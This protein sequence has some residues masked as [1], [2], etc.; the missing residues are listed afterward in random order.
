MLSARL[1][2]SNSYPLRP[3]R[4][5][6]IQTKREGV[7]VKAQ[8]FIRLLKLVWGEYDIV[9]MNEWKKK[10]VDLQRTWVSKRT[11]ILV[12]HRASSNLFWL[13]F[14]M[15]A[16]KLFSPQSLSLKQT[17]NCGFSQT[18]PRKKWFQNIHCGFIAKLWK[19]IK[20]PHKCI[21]MQS[22]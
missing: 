21:L 2:R 19:A 10:C 20:D 11:V 13:F 14:Q 15:F 12:Y 16:D 7:Y 8:S 4:V 22:I 1:C 18:F 5:T 17:S 6:W 9:A 3:R